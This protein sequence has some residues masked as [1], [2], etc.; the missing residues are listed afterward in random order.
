MDQATS[1]MDGPTEQG[2]LLVIT[3]PATCYVR[4]IRELYQLSDRGCLSLYAGYR[5]LL[6]QTSIA[7]TL[8]SQLE[9][10]VSLAPTR[11]PERS[12]RLKRFLLTQ[13]HTNTILLQRSEG[14]IFCLLCF[15]ARLTRLWPSCHTDWG[16]GGC[17]SQING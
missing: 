10:R 9:R 4:I 1:I 2:R 14:R 6:A 15:T 3:E 11:T 7:Y 8:A 16:G 13:P 5:S 12:S 17:S